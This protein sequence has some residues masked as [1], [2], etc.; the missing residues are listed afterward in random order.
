MLK[1]VL[2]I[3]QILNGPPGSEVVSAKPAKNRV[4]SSG[5]QWARKIYEYL[6]LP[7]NCFILGKYLLKAK[8][9]CF[10]SVVRPTVSILRFNR[11]FIQL[12]NKSDSILVFGGSC[13]VEIVAK[14]L[15]FSAFSHGTECAQPFSTKR[16]G[17]GNSLGRNMNPRGGGTMCWIEVKV[18]TTQGFVCKP[19]HAMKYTCNQSFG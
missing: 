3:N 9:I 4:Y 17:L 15:L 5:A 13:W 6:I 10:L 7:S 16:Q 12:Q 8:D 1:S 19:V 2:K 14:Q 11:I 18:C